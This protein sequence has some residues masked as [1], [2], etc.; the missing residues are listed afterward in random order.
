MN[1]L[2]VESSILYRLLLRLRLH[3]TATVQV[4]GKMQATVQ[5]TDC[6]YS[7]TGY[8]RKNRASYADMYGELFEYCC[9]L[10]R[11]LGA[12]AAA[13]CSLYSYSG[14]GSLA[15]DRQAFNPLGDASG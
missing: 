12:A 14:G 7:Y 4:G 15:S 13:A 1:E 2:Q 11:L 10:F 6:W 3:A 8:F 9:T 5:T